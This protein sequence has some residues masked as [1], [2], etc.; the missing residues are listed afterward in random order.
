MSNLLRAVPLS[1]ALGAEVDDFDITAEHTP[2]EEAELRRLFKQHHLL[3]VRGQ[4][5]TAADHDR[6]LAC[7]GPIQSNRVGE[8][9]GYVTNQDDPRSLFGDELW[10]LLWHNDGAYGPKPG[11]ATSLWAEEIAPTATP[12]QF[13]NV[14]E[15]IDR[16]PAELRRKVE[17]LRIINAVDRSFLR[18]YER[19]PYDEIVATT[20]PERYV[21]QEHPVLFDAPHLDA[22][23]IIASEQMTVHVVGLDQAEGDAFLDELF[24]I[25]YADDNVY[26]H[27][28]QRNDVLVWDNIALHHSRPDEPGPE[29]RHL[30]RQCLDGWYTDDG[31]LLD[32]N[33]SLAPRA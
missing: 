27:H 29:P 5:V 14:V 28:W 22:K 2:E 30:R 23:A 16:L 18:T 21:T 13:A 8:A 19:V 9:A 17:D 31:G 3:L 20:E 10:R 32:W 6:F 24:A 12:T 25:I 26:T 11:I 33:L 4:E 7:F 15:V 1:D